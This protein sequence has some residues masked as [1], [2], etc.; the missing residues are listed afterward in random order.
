[1]LIVFSFLIRCSNSSVSYKEDIPFLGNYFS[2]F[3]EEPRELK[4]PNLYS[5]TITEYSKYLDGKKVF[6]NPGQ[7]KIENSI[8]KIRNKL[9]EADI[10]LKVARHLQN[11]LLS[12]GSEVILSR[13]SDTSISD[14]NLIDIANNSGA[15]IFLSIHHN[16]TSDTSDKSTNFT[17]T[18][19]HSQMGKYEY[20]P[21]SRNLA[22]YI[23]RDLSYVI[24]NSGGPG[25]FDG[26]Y[27]DYTIIPEKGFL[28]LRESRMT[29]VMVMCA[30]YT[31][32]FEM[33]R[34]NL[35]SFNKI[36]AWGIFKGLYK[37]FKAGIP[38]I[39]FLPN[40]S[41]YSGD[42]LLL[43]YNLIDESPIDRNSLLVY[44]DKVKQNYNYDELTNILSVD[45]GNI[46][47]GDHIIKLICG[48]HEGNF[49]YPYESQ[50]IIQ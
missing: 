25:S 42:E 22:K 4:D 35:D 8:I 21:S 36:E 43:S 5:K 27:S 28:I 13:D 49:S 41:Y 15:E 14:S 46:D 19:Y 6:I 24:R 32:Q 23:Q 38:E 2:L 16:A 3:I 1:M 40:Q 20:D 26:T 9:D 48:N 45:I 47:K 29:T 7:N 37:Y 34:L 10:N 33:E 39:R 44:F 50:I 17:A 11:F 30:F 18:Y 12:V 31:N